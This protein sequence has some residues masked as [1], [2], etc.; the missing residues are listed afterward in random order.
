MVN[1]LEV[2]VLNI[3]KQDIINRLEALDAK[4][5]KHEHQENTIFDTED[6][7]VKNKLNGYL[8][9]R[10]KKNLKTNKTE[11][12]FTLKR[13]VSHDELRRNIEIETKFEDKEALMEILQLINVKK[14]HK[15]TKERISYEKDGILFEIDTWD[16][17]TYPDTY[18]EL[19]VKNTDDLKKAIDMLDLKEEDVTTKSFDQLRKDIGMEVL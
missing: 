7:F 18:M 10:E 4:L 9:I 17:D 16:K 2:K 13:N 19:E 12:I 6:R 3:E 11:C 5:V 15:G 1:E 8:R 14:L